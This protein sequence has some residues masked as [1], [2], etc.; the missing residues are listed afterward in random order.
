[1]TAVTKF[2]EQPKVK[3]I[4]KEL[5]NLNA[6]ENKTKYEKYLSEQ[7]IKGLVQLTNLK[8]EIDQLET[9][10]RKMNP[11]NKYQFNKNK[12]DKKKLN[13]EK[14]KLIQLLLTKIKFKNLRIPPEKEQLY[15]N[16]IFNHSNLPSYIDEFFR[17][18]PNS[19]EK[20]VTLKTLCEYINN[21]K[22][23]NDN[24]GEKQT[25]KKLLQCEVSGG[26]NPFD[27]I[28]HKHFHNGG[29]PLDTERKLKMFVKKHMKQNP[30]LTQHVV[31]LMN[32][33]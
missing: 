22:L 32:A 25:V 18:N 26:S 13:G 11:I 29:R 23:N 4:N 10:Q 12:N 8:N 24:D 30:N 33:T 2:Q 14:N 16:N 7:I 28:V 20:N 1:M 3:R 27:T 31:T 9:L 21:K 5:E 17:E 6:M 15:Y 19:N